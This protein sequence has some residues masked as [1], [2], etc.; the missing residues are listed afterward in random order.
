MCFR[1]R[2][3]WLA[4]AIPLGFEPYRDRALLPLIA[5]L[6]ESRGHATRRELVEASQGYVHIEINSNIGTV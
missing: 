2:L 4:D 6:G 1:A 3:G 5:S